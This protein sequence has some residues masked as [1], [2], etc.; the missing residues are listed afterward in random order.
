MEHNSRRGVR[1]A[2]L[3]AGGLCLAG[4]GHRTTVARIRRRTNA[5]LD[6]LYAMPGDG[7]Q[8][9]LDTTDGGS[10][11]VVER[12]VG[13]P[14]VLLHGVGLGAACW[15]PQFHLGA[16][17]Y[18][19]IAIDVR[20]HG[21]SIVGSAG[22][23]HVQA[24]ADL[25]LLL[26]Q[27]DLNGAI[28]CG[29]SMGGVVL[30]RFCAD[31]PELVRERVAGLVFM[32]SADK[33]KYPDIARQAV[34]SVGARL[35]ARAERGHPIKVTGKPGDELVF[36]RM[37]FGR[38]P[39]GA[40]VEVARQLGHDASDAYRTH[41]WVD[42]QSFDNRDALARVNKPS[43][44]LVGGFDSQTPKSMAQRLQR[45]LRDAQMIVFPGAG[46]LLMLERPREVMDAIDGLV[47]RLAG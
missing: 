10:V 2:A 33:D 23:G 15:A 3:C 45:G 47:R 42:L 14:L 32:D 29:H 43:V 7:T 20:G 16:D 28:L 18:R 4:L 40:A 1:A 38:K 13:R 35:I 31:Y 26:E 12:G 41:V 34:M 36:A 5:D 6:A 17:R 19:V 30:G 46:H 25:A 39:S 37:A 11:H 9:D 21:R 8:F 24:A 44:V 27:L 22:V